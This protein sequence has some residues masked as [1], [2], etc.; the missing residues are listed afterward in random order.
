MT[1]GFETLCD[2][3]RDLLQSAAHPEWRAPMLATLTDDHFSDP[4]W[5]YERK[6][7]GERALAFRDGDRIR[8]LT[9]NRKALNATYPELADAIARQAPGDLVA[10]G[11]IV[12][13]DGDV[14]SFS[15]LQARMQIKDADTARESPVAVYYYLFDLVHFAGH[16]LSALPLRARKALLKRVIDFDDPLRFTPHRNADGGAYL[17]EACEKGWEGLIAKRADAGYR[18]ARSTDWLKFKCVKGQELVIGGFT[19]PK[20]NRVGFGALLVGYYDDDN[21]LRYAGKVGTGFDDDFLC[22]FR[23]RL[24]GL[25]R[26]TSPFSDEVRETSATFVSP[27]LVGEFGFTEWTDSGKLRH[28]RFLGLRDDKP[29]RAVVRERPRAT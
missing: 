26:K 17:Q 2:E 18:H 13:F 4:D 29:A 1:T 7:D 12:A 25:S 27:E 8:L 21:A 3:N 23:K 16:D 22:S 19:A 10:D 28:P 24:D 20:G 11:E 15:K 9:R 5:I 14:T 6:L